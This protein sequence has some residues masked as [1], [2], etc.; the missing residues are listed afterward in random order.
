MLLLGRDGETLVARSYKYCIVCSAHVTPTGSR[1]FLR[2]QIPKST[3]DMVFQP[4]VLNRKT[5]GPSRNQTSH[6]L[7]ESETV[8]SQSFVQLPPASSPPR[9]RIWPPHCPMLAAGHIGRGGLEC[10][11]QTSYLKQVVWHA[12]FGFRRWEGYVY[13]HR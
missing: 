3:I 2:N 13:S 10:F 5:P 1:H 9:Q 4:Q 11:R 7:G 6:E 12:S 8:L